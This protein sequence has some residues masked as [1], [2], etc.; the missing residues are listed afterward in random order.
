MSD[1]KGSRPVVGVQKDI[2]EGIEKD[3]VAWVVPGVQT[4]R[5]S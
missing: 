4:P 3:I 2:E 5:Y 1:E